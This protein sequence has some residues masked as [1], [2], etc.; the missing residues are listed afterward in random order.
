MAAF[1]QPA[2]SISERIVAAKASASGLP[3]LLPPELPPLDFRTVMLSLT[4]LYW[5]FNSSSDIL[6][7]RNP[8]HESISQSC[9]VFPAQFAASEAEHAMLPPAIYIGSV[10][11]IHLPFVPAEESRINVLISYCPFKYFILGSTIFPPI[12][13]PLTANS[14]LSVIIKNFAWRSNLET[15]FMSFGLTSIRLSGCTISSYNFVKYAPTEPE[16]PL[17]P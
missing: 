15:E 4:Q 10:E 12:H 17:I 6:E 16:L 5:A 7:L 11:G 1:P 9:F 14:C 2:L 3:P 13:V 8:Q